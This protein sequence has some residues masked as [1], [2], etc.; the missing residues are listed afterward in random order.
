M[1]TLAASMSRPADER[2]ILGVCAGVSRRTEVDVTIVRVIAAIG[3]ALLTTPFLV[4]YAALALIVPRDDGRQLLGGVPKDRRETLIGWT[5]VAA[6]AGLVIASPSLF[7]FGGDVSLFEIGLLAF[8]IGLVAIAVG[9]SDDRSEAEEHGAEPA[10][11]VD[12]VPSAGATPAAMV[13]TRPPAAA[14]APAEDLR[15]TDEIDGTAETVEQETA[16]PASEPKADRGPSIFIAAFGVITAV[17]GLGAIVIAVGDI[18]LT[19]L[20]VAVTAGVIAVGC[21]IVA[22]TANGRRGAVPLLFLGLLFGLVAA[23]AAI[24]REEFDRGVGYE[25]VRALDAADLRSGYEWGIGYLE[26]DVRDAEL[27]AGRTVMPIEGG[28]GAVRVIVPDDL[29][30][31]STGDSVDSSIPAATGRAGGRAGEREPVL[32]V[33]ADVRAGSIEIDR[34][35]RG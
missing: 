5:L 17:I 11:P 22:I 7:G 31:V 26:V 29:A 13:P 16:K 4:A 2:M 9:R 1:S 14:L 8:A 32:V 15:G 33:D 12:D 25:Q 6:A 23:T 19:A 28:F 34:E 24:G 21:G 3:L 27:P 20:A 35:G 10:L 30:V 18:T